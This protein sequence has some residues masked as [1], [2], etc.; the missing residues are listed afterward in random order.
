ML[1]SKAAMLRGQ[2]CQ[3][4]KLPS[5]ETGGTVSPQAVLMQEIPS[6]ASTYD[7]DLSLQSTTLTPLAMDRAHV[8]SILT[9]TL[10]LMTRISMRSAAPAPSKISAQVLTLFIGLRERAVRVTQIY[11]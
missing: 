5:L 1:L 4:V 6:V 3:A 7:T 10:V 2:S 9:I 8:R 11:W